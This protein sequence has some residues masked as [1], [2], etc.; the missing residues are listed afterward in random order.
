M[1]DHERKASWNFVDKFLAKRR[2]AKVLPY[3]TERDVVLDVGCGRGDNLRLLSQYIKQG[4][5]IDAFD[6][7]FDEK[8]LSFIKANLELGK[9]NV[10]ANCV[11]KII[12]LAVLE[13]LNN[14]KPLLNEFSR[15]LKKGGL[16]ILTTP[17]RYSKPVL[18]TLAFLHVINADEIKDHKHYYDLNEIKSLFESVGFKLIKLNYFQLG[19]NTFGLFQKI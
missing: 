2:L 5:G 11:N 16:V 9:F 18:E 17:S 14:P 4:I 15:L 7:K 1:V 3:V 10:G 19:M 8:N 12:F 13:H 6:T